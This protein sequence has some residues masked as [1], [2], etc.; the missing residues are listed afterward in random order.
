MWGRV[1]DLG[2]GGEEGDRLDHSSLG[3]SKVKSSFLAFEGHLCDKDTWGQVVSPGTT[4]SVLRKGFLH[5]SSP[6]SLFHKADWVGTEA[7]ILH[8]QCT[9]LKLVSITQKSRTL[10]LLLCAVLCVRCVKGYVLGENC[11]CTF[12]I[13]FS[14]KPKTPKN[15]R[16]IVLSTFDVEDFSYLFGTFYV[17]YM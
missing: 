10:P 9:C 3:R 17:F 15:M 11:P 6:A 12:W 7:P 1:G 16:K 2:G 5:S 13:Y 4:V 8:G 14:Q